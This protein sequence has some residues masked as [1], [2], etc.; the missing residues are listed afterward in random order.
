MPIQRSSKAFGDYL[1]KVR[2]RSTSNQ[3]YSAHGKPKPTTRQRSFFRLLWEFL[4]LLRNFRVAIAFALTTLTITTLLGLIPPAATKIAIDYVLMP[5][6]QPVPASIQPWVPE[7]RV[8]MLWLIGAVVV[9]ITL[10][11]SL[12]RLWGRWHA[13]RTVQRLQ[14]SVRKKVFEHAVRLPLHRIYHLKSGGVASL[15]REDA[16]SVAELVFS[17]LYNPWR[18]IIQ[19]VGSLLVLA[20]VDWQLLLGAILL[21]PMIYWTHRAWISHIR[22]LYRDIREQRQEIDSHSTEAFGGMRV[23]RAFGRQK[24]EARRFVS[25]NHLMSRQQIYVWWWSRT[26][27]VLWDIFIPLAS[28][29]LLIYGGTQVIQGHLSIGDLM[30]FLFYLAMLLEPI[31]VL[32]NSATGFQNSLAALDRVLDVLGEPLEMS[33]HPGTRLVRPVEVSGQIRLNDVSFSYPESD[34]LVLQ[35]INLEVQPGETI[36]LVGRSGA[37]KTT[38]CNLIARFYDPTSGSIELDGVDLREINVESYR[39]LL[40]IVEQEVFLFDGSVAENIGYGAREATGEQIQ[41][42]AEAA[43]AHE[44][45]VNLPNGYDTRIGERGVKLSGGQRQRLAIA[46][47]LL[48]DPRI[49]ILDEATSNLDSESEGYIQQSLEHLM[50]GRTSFVIAHRLSTI[51]RADRILVLDQGRILEIGTHEDLLASGGQYAEMVK[52]QT[53]PAS[54]RVPFSADSFQSS[55]AG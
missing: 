22:P 16:G 29:A 41:Q 43:Y 47:A 34:K 30:M 2:E 17:L 33:E 12:I 5:E 44:F 26:V 39:K 27:E 42:A 38:L 48:A 50:Q 7:S 10:V 6:P 24:S 1:Q 23:V 46:R 18:A 54:T 20:W 28:A 37:G 9:S 45:I 55:S 31:A 21:L 53:S 14:V 3:H 15:L 4:G 52:L 51:R 11:E 13:T 40:G 32:A 49:L 19:L 36:A 35:D 25:G 8:E